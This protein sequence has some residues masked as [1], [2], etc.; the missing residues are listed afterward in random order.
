MC[1]L[2]NHKKMVQLRSEH[3]KISKNLS[4]LGNLHLSIV[5]RYECI[6]CIFTL[7]N[8]CVGIVHALCLGLQS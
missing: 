3:A 2:P 6:L 1:F 4:L 7:L 8:K 5:F